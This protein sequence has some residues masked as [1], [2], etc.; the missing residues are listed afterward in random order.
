MN[1]VRDFFYR[2]WEFDRLYDTVFVKPFVYIT[3]VNKSDIFD[4]ISKRL[5]AS[6]VRVN[7]W[8]SFSQNGSLRWY[9]AGILFG[10]IF[11][12]TLELLL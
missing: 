9:V 8:F 6:S 12:V 10:I 5:A 2:G 4:Q 7:Q 11:I 3:Q 1:A